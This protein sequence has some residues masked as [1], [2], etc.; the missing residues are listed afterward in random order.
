MSR[1]HGLDLRRDQIL[2]LDVIAVLDD[3]RDPL[4][5]TMGMIALVAEQADWP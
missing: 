2:D 4:T 5:V 3:L 1:P